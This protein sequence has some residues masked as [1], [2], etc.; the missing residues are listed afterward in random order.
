MSESSNT[1]LKSELLSIKFYQRKAPLIEASI[2]RPCKWRV[3]SRVRTGLLSSSL[4]IFSS[5]SIEP[6]M[7][8]N[9]D[10]GDHGMAQ[11]YDN[12]LTPSLR[13]SMERQDCDGNDI[14]PRVAGKKWFCAARRLHRGGQLGRS[15]STSW[16]VLLDRVL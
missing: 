7:Q 6:A 1:E 5:L 8:G 2:E 13:P 4:W 15:G 3:F 14:L 9:M 16:G 11:S 10:Y 12:L